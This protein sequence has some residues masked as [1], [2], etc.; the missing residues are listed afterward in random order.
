[1]DEFDDMVT[2]GLQKGISEHCKPI[3]EVKKKKRSQVALWELRFR[4]AH[5]WS[6]EHGSNSSPSLSCR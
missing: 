3:I 5:E 6:R 2:S 1:M 4:I